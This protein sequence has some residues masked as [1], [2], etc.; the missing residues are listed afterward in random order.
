MTKQHR[1]CALR[2]D[3][4]FLLFLTV[5]PLIDIYR[6]FFGD[7]LSIGPF[8]VEELANLAFLFVLFLT[9]LLQCLHHG[10]LKN[11]FP[12]AGYFV[13]AGVYLVLHCLNMRQFDASILPESA[14]S[15]LSEAYY[16][17]RT[18]LCP[19]LLL[20]LVWQ[21]GI[22]DALFARAIRIVVFTISG[23][24]VATNLLGISLVAYS[25]ENQQIRGSIFSWPSLSLSMTE[26]ELALYTSKGWFQSANQVSALLFSLCPFIVKDVIRTPSWKNSLLLCLQVLSMILLGTRTA[27]WGCL[28]IILLMGLCALALH[29]LH[30]ERLP[31]WNVLPL[32]LVIVLCGAALGYVSPGQLSKRLNQQDEVIDRPEPNESPDAADLPGSLTL[33]EYLDEY[34]YNYYINPW[35]LEIYP[36]END[37]T[38]WRDILARDRTLNIDNRAFKLHM[39]SRIQERNAR[40][41]D[42]WLGFGY[43]TNA[44]YTERDY[45]YQ[46]YVFGIL[47][48]LLLM[49][50][51]FF[52]FLYGGVRMLT[53]AREFLS[54]ENCALL[55]AIGCML[56]IAYLSGHVFGILLNMF[57]LGTYCGK[58]LSNLKKRPS[59]VETEASVQ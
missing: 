33:A 19:V 45:A 58:L 10:R 21:C 4:L 25:G 59:T 8:A 28:I 29:I 51:F 50:P 49:G 36:A 35:F 52:A 42:K 3:F 23:V 39:L 2:I 11:L 43:T 16:I 32:L 48:V 7:M 54:L 47:G 46:Y 6:T 22:E 17:F 18:Y 40:S 1:P 14:V 31:K 41:A 34:A 44:P 56:G 12:Y 13:L 26:A 15:S 20:F 30:L 24:M 5:Q 38:F 37:E 55:M 27:S 53:R 9:A 57:F